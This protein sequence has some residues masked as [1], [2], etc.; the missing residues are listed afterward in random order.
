GDEVRLAA[1]LGSFDRTLAAT[2]WGDLMRV[3]IWLS[4]GLALVAAFAL[5]WV[6]FADEG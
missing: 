5:L 2:G 6:A 1:I 4:A 3:L